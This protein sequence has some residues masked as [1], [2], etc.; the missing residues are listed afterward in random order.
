LLSPVSC[1][2]CVMPRINKV[3]FQSEAEPFVPPLDQAELALDA[4]AYTNVEDSVIQFT[5]LRTVDT[6][7]RVSVDW[8]IT[9]ARGRQKLAY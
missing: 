6:T 9:N 5:I 7:E 2:G 8:A 3:I 4:A 1:V